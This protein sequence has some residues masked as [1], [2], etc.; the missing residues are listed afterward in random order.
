MM[1]ANQKKHSKVNQPTG[2]KK[3]EQK[4]KAHAAKSPPQALPHEPG[5]SPGAVDVT[6]IIPEDVRVDPDITEGHPGYEESGGSEL[7]PPR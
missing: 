3:G 5:V 2:V 1:A 6:G 4:S 7:H